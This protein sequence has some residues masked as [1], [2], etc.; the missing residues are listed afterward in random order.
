[1]KVQVTKQVTETINVE[2]GYY[3]S[4][5]IDCFYYLRE[6]GVLVY[7]SNTM[8][9]FTTPDKAN[10]ANDIKEIASDYRPC[11]ESEFEAAKDNVLTH[12]KHYITFPETAS[13]VNPASGQSGNNNMQDPNQQLANQEATEQ[14]QPANEQAT[15]SAAQDQAMGVDSEEG[16]AEG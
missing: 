14:A 3:K 7:V 11:E 16:G 13:A 1:M 15:E 9:Y 4:K 5:L 8:T 6:S 12:L 10:Y 2:P